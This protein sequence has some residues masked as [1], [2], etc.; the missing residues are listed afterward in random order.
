[1]RTSLA[2]AAVVTAMI[3][4]GSAEARTIWLA[5]ASADQFIARHYPHA[6]IPG[7]IN[8]AF[9]YYAHHRLRHGW[10]SCIVPAMGARSDGQVSTCYVKF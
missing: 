1:M 6:E 10:G 7:S 4:A 2:A 8:A 5:G 9:S 3:S